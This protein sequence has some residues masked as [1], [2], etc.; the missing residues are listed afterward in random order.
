MFEL[1]FRIFILEPS[2]ILTSFTVLTAFEEESDKPL[3]VIA[4]SA[5]HRMTNLPWFPGHERKFTPT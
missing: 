4:V 3:A 5:C 2:C 1:H